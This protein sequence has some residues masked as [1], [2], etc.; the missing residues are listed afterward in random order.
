M[1]TKRVEPDFQLWA[2]K[3]VNTF[4][5]VDTRIA[6]KEV[7]AALLQSKQVGQTEGYEKG[8]SEG[9]EACRTKLYKEAI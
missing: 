6:I 9:F 5:L 2:E 4:E 1:N 8:Y 3:L 7:L